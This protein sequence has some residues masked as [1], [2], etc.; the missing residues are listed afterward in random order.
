MSGLQRCRRDF[1]REL[2]LLVGFE[3]LERVCERTK[4]RLGIDLLVLCVGIE[5]FPEL[6]PGAVE[7]VR[8]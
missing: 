5:D 2:E 8:R 6:H 1:R 4:Y 3:P 7:P